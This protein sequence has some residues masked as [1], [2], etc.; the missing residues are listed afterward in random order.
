MPVPLVTNAVTSYF[1]LSQDSVGNA[2][3]CSAAPFIFT[4]DTQEA[5]PVITGVSNATPNPG[6][7]TTWVTASNAPPTISG[8]GVVGVTAAT[9][10]LYSVA[11]CG[12]G[13][14][15]AGASSPLASDGTWSI[16]FTPSMAAMFVGN[17]STNLYPASSDLAGNSAC[18]ATG[19]GY[20]FVP[21][22]AAPASLATNPIS[23][24]SV[25]N[26]PSIT[27]NTQVLPNGVTSTVQLFTGATAC[28]SAVPNTTSTAGQGGSFSIPLPI[29]SKVAN[30]S[31]TTFWVQVTDS[32]GNSTCSTSV[33]YT[34]V[35]SEPA[36]TG[37]GINPTSPSTVNTQP[38][39]SGT[40]QVA[41]AGATVAIQLF[42][43]ATSCQTA[44][45]A[46]PT[47][48]G[49]GGAFSIQVP[50]GQVTANS[51][52]NFWIKVTD[53]AGN[54]VCSTAVP[55]VYVPSESAPASLASTPGPSPIGNVPNGATPTL[56]GTT[57]VL[58]AGATSTV[59]IYK[60]ATACLT[61][62]PGAVSSA[63]Q[64]GAFSIPIPNAQALSGNTANSF[65]AKVT[66]SL[67][68]S[69][70]SAAALNYV[71]VPSEAA[72]SGLA[73]TPGPSPVGSVANGATPTISGST[74]VLPAGVTST[75]QLFT[76]ASACLT[77]VP[78]STSTASQG[79][80]FSIPL[81][82]PSALAGNTST[83]FWVKVVDS[84]ANS[85][86]SAAPL[87]YVYVPSESAPSGLSSNPG[88]S[89]V[90]NMINGATPTIGG[91][92]QV[93]PG[94][95]TSTVQ[96]FTGATAC[97]TAVPNTT[98]SPGQ[99]GAFSIPLPAASA[100]GSNTATN[101]WA[102]VTDSLANS[103]CSLVLPY[104]YVASEAAPT[105]GGTNSPNNTATPSIIG[106]TQTVPAAVTVSVQLFTGASGC[107]TSV[108]SLT[109][110]GQG[111][112]FVV[113]PS[114]PLISGTTTNFWVKV[115]D[116]VGN[117]T[118]AGP[119]A[120][121]FVASETAPVFAANT[122]PASP[123]NATATPTFTGTVQNNPAGVTQ[124]V[125]LYSGNNCQSLIAGNTA[126]ASGGAFSLG[127]IP[128]V[129][130]PSSNPFTIKVSDNVGNTSSCSSPI[131]YVYVTSTA[132]PVFNSTTAPASPSN[133]SGNVN[134]S[135]AADTGASL[136]IA[137]ATV[138]LYAGD[139]N[140]AGRVPGTQT[141]SGS[142]V[143]FASGIGVPIVANASTNYYAFAI[144]A[145]TNKSACSAPVTFTDAQ[146][147]PAS[148]LKRAQFYNGQMQ[149]C[150]GNYTFP[151]RACAAGAHVC[152]ASEYAALNGNT[153][154][155]DHYWTDDDLNYLYAPGVCGGGGSNTCNSGNC[156]AT[157]LSGPITQSCG[158]SSPF[159]VCDPIHPTDSA[160][161][162]C[163]WV[164]CGFNTVGSGDFF[165]GCGSTT[166]GVLCC[167]GPTVV[168][169]DAATGLDTNVGSRA[170]PFK[171]IKKAL[172]VAINA[173]DTIKV[174]PGTYDAASGE[175]FPI[176][177]PAGVLLLGDEA[178]RGAGPPTATKINGSGT[179]NMAAGS[180]IAGFTVTTSTNALTL[181][182]SGVTVRNNSLISNGGYGIW[183]QGSSSG[184][185]ILLNNI[186]GQG[187]ANFGGIDVFSGALGGKVES[188]SITYNSFGIVLNT[189]GPNF[190][191]GTPTGSVG[192]NTLSCN[193]NVDFYCNNSS[194]SGIQV[195]FA[196]WDHAPVNISPTVTS[197]GMDLYYDNSCGITFG[198][199]NL[200]AAAPCP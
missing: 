20:V 177:V 120:Y 151:A 181:N 197:G 125:Q 141:A 150:A 25:S 105:L 193:I 11:G 85:A 173:N 179:V 83:N 29:A 169:V 92:T 170:S 168:Y 128:A 45:G 47:N 50:A 192:N 62:I 6:G 110:L 51:A 195:Q 135:G 49:Q 2:S 84:L 180:T 80:A 73:T 130:A 187:T 90:G 144:D 53:S 131:T 100:L 42:K 104:V 37:M 194:L 23:P 63:G 185:T 18:D 137:P 31:A 186:G 161:N 99:G 149:G 117:S 145:A 166:A 102:K 200:L 116:T 97:A 94:G 188:N 27:G 127:L 24:T 159:R 81:P 82:A 174:S 26:T 71:F 123:S 48:I 175:A 57:Q 1:A 61:A 143:T 95:V 148:G 113:S 162:S 108:G 65:W 172:T 68:N 59:Q 13:G 190:G 156:V 133:A 191:D 72:P 178:T 78:N 4:S 111:G 87:N 153:P 114:V 154:P 157:A 70:C 96:L 91:S 9:I 22:E 30:N 66:D 43:G 163:N 15:I 176:N 69:A 64:G 28:A 44:I 165:G 196:H 183:V 7:S 10:Q 34:Y 17:T 77:A 32:L 189:P 36:P 126:A 138:Y 8:T 155:Q 142:A 88:P 56:S 198:T 54:S 101:F 76:G 58:P 3:T 12:S 38:T 124:T 46:A 39:V 60:G 118:C 86:C 79:G 5:A 134:L 40:T 103:S 75:V 16:P 152:G 67:G 35:P 112:A 167:K 98:T 119:R 89:P 136:G 115:T 182:G 140:C 171:T 164:N 129:T 41:V 184:H 106:T 33:N 109:G 93:L 21:L 147:C 199:A 122:T 74:Q 52:T 139:P 158:A 14:L 132:T 121:V 55:Y 19:I 107:T 160:S 146:F